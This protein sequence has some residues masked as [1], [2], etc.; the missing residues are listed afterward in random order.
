LENE[1]VKGNSGP[2]P[3]N[4]ETDN[5]QNCFYPNNEKDKKIAI[6][7]LDQLSNGKPNQL[8]AMIKAHNFLYDGPALVF[9]FKGSKGRN[10]VKISLRPNDL[11]LMEFWNVRGTQVTEAGTYENV[12]NDRLSEMFKIET[13]LDLTLGTMGA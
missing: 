4:V 7:I 5:M 6:T 12:Y 11:Y 3:E 8:I 1:N 13:G 2:N 10:R 9:A